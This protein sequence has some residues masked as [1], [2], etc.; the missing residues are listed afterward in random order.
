MQ[1]DL[2]GE[3]VHPLDVNGVLKAHGVEPAGSDVRLALVEQDHVIIED[4]RDHAVA[5]NA[6]EHH[7]ARIALAAQKIAAEGIAALLGGADLKAARARRKPRLGKRD[8]DKVTLAV[9]GRARKLAG[10]GF[11]QARGTAPEK[12]PVGIDAGLRGAGLDPGRGHLA[13]PA[14]AIDGLRRDAERTRKLRIAGNVKRAHEPGQT[15]GGSVAG[16]PG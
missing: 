10:P 3:L 16:L 6:H 15:L 1:D 4:L 5:G 2:A 13:A 12:E 9:R 7:A 11:R 8:G 14:R